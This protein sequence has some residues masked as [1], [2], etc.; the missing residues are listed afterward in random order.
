MTGGDRVRQV[1][2]FTVPKL[3]KMMVKSQELAFT[4]SGRQQTIDCM[5]VFVCEITYKVAINIVTAAF[6]FH[7]FCEI[8]GW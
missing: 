1:A 2:I 8:S 4:T 6:L 5:Y 7:I 3:R